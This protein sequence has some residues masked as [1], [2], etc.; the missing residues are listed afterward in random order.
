M[1][2]SIVIA[3][4]VVALICGLAVWLIDSAPFINGTWKTIARWIIIVGFVWWALQ[5]TG[6]LGYLRHV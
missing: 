1:T 6:V 5:K 2:F 3:L 4:L